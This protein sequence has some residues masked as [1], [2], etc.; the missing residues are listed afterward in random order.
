MS[1]A[2]IMFLIG[3]KEH[4]KKLLKA[5][6]HS[7]QYHGLLY[8]H[9]IYYTFHSCISLN[10]SVKQTLA[11]VFSDKAK[12][13]LLKLRNHQQKPEI[14]ELNWW[15][16][17]APVQII[18]CL[19]HWGSLRLCVTGFIFQRTIKFFKETETFLPA[20]I[21]RFLWAKSITK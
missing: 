16:K 2:T 21:C 4:T 1:Y 19:E 14:I 5:F 12:R 11:W 18:S 3:P 15:L 13:L 10:K 8:R 6:L 7:C 9:Y 17:G 20:F